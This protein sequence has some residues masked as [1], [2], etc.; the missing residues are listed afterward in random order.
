MSIG[1]LAA[2]TAP[3]SV[4]PAAARA[5][6]ELTT[7]ES[8]DVAVVGG[9]ARVTVRFT[10]EDETVRSIAAHA[11]DRTRTL[12]QVVSWRITRRDGSRWMPVP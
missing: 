7:V 6:A 11:V 8:S 2:G 3:S 5:V 10:A 9:S 12:A 4:V 1:A